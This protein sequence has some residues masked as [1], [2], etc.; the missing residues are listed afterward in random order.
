MVDVTSISPAASLPTGCISG[1]ISRLHRARLAGGYHP[2]SDIT[3]STWQVIQHSTIQH[4]LNSTHD[5]YRQFTSMPIPARSGCV[6]AKKTKRSINPYDPALRTLTEGDPREPSVCQMFLRRY[7]P[8]PPGE[9][10]DDY[11]PFRKDVDIF[12][13]S[14]TNLSELRRPRRWCKYAMSDGIIRFGCIQKHPLY[15]CIPGWLVDA[16]NVRTRKGT[17]LLWCT[18]VRGVN[19]YLGSVCS[20]INLHHLFQRIESVNHDNFTTILA[21]LT[22]LSTVP[23][24]PINRRGMKYPNN[25][26]SA[27]TFEDVKR[28][29]LQLSRTTKR[30][31]NNKDLLDSLDT[32]FARLMMVMPHKIGTNSFDLIIQ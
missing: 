13:K 6:S 28:S 23:L 4:Q 16:I 18:D 19:L 21:H 5:M 30:D 1:D 25:A 20:L 12:D 27:R 15:K 7:T 8:L 9:G 2:G 14:V 31:N 10:D 11:A 17:A 32:F 3:A 24:N 22:V 29:L 26:I